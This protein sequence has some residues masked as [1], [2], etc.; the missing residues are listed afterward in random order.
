MAKSPLDISFE[1][2][3]AAG[4]H[5]S[6]SANREARAHG[7]EPMGLTGQP[8]PTATVLTLGAHAYRPAASRDPRTGRFV[9]QPV[10]SSG[11]IR[12]A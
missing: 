1:E 3:A 12:R 8:T 10:R 11:N 5:A 6:E 4:R 2:L 7:I 9:S